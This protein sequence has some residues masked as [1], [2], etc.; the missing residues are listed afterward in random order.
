MSMRSPVSLAARRAFWPFLPIASES[1]LSGTVTSTAGC[2]G[3]WPSSP[4]AA[5]GASRSVTDDTLAGESARATNVAASY[6]HS[7]MSIFSP[8]RSRLITWIRVPRRP[9]Q[10]P[11]GSTSRFV[12][13]T[14]T[15]A[16]SPGSRAT[17]FTTTIPSWTSGISVSK[18]PGASATA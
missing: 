10:A 16:R 7:T 13:A 15:F 9:T 8:R 12:E 1:W 18:S 14:A 17:A 3:S 11:I 5:G 4:G 2:G 6:D